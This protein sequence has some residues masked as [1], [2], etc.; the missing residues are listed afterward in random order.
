MKTFTFLSSIIFVIFIVSSCNNNSPCPETRDKGDV[1]YTQKTMEALPY[2]GKD[3][4]VFKSTLDE[5][6]ILEV[7]DKEDTV[8]S[9]LFAGVCETDPGQRVYINYQKKTRRI[10]LQN[11]SIKATFYVWIGTE[12]SFDEYN[13]YDVIKMSIPTADTDQYQ[14]FKLLVDRRN[15][16]DQE[17]DWMNSLMVYNTEIEISGNTFFDTYNLKN[18]HPDESH[19]IYY[20]F[21]NGIVSFVGPDETT[22]VFDRF[23]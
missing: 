19:L 23:E 21:E 13:P 7:I 17:Y 11:D 6:L 22:W 14:Y 15:I 3:K 20:N 1:F 10:L 2:I 18:E 4:V 8:I 16:S 12:L 5:E 9:G